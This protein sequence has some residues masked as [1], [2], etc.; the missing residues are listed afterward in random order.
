MKI[1]Q[2]EFAQ[3]LGVTPQYLS[4]IKNRKRFPSYSLAKQLSEHLG[5]SIHIIYEGGH[6]E[7]LAAFSRL[8]GTGEDG[9][10]HELSGSADSDTRV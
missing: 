7:L 4:M 9:E 6:E 3:I 2:K 10:H 5:V 1:S 8:K